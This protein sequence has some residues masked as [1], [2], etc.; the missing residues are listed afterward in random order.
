MATA[1]S[2]RAAGRHGGRQARGDRQRAKD[3]HHRRRGH[4][5]GPRQGAARE[6]TRS[7]FSSASVVAVAWSEFAEKEEENEIRMRNSRIFGTSILQGTYFACS[8]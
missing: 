6:I 4:Q 2:R 5:N 3:Q 1:E 7:E 8:R